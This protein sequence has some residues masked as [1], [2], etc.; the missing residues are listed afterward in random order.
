MQQSQAK[1][2][3][4]CKWESRELSDS[5]KHW[6]SSD[7]KVIWHD[8][9]QLNASKESYEEFTLL[10]FRLSGLSITVVES[11]QKLMGNLP[12]SKVPWKL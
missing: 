8:S 5:R 2:G 1:F 6:C 4:I 12:I 11:H 10:A 9:Y 7:Y 3:A